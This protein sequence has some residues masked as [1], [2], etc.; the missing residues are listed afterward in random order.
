MKLISS[1][2]SGSRGTRADRGGR[3]TVSAGFLPAAGAGI[4]VQVDR[5][6]GD[7][8]PDKV[9][10]IDS[11]ALC[12]PNDMHVVCLYRKIQF[13]C[14]IQYVLAESLIGLIPAVHTPCNFR[15]IDR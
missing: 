14:F 2:S 13:A 7:G 15:H 6:P 4:E 12:R 1:A 3:P 8:D 9:A 11:E 10:D 5:I